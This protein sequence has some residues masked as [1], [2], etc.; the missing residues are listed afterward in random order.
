MMMTT[1]TTPTT[2]T[3]S[4]TKDKD[5]VRLLEV[6]TDH[7]TL[8]RGLRELFS[9]SLF[10]SLERD[11]EKYELVKAILLTREDSIRCTDHQQNLN[12]LATASEFEDWFMKKPPPTSPVMIYTELY[13]RTSNDERKIEELRKGVEE[14]EEEEEEEKE[15]G[16]RKGGASKATCKST[17]RGMERFRS[18]ALHTVCQR[19]A[20]LRMAEGRPS[21]FI[22]S[23]TPDGNIRNT[24]TA[25]GLV[26]ET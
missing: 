4:T 8:S 6:P 26:E 17:K 23:K 19:L 22:P 2:P 15:K 12:I 24:R 11:T 25:F 1:T 13:V 7:K 20:M 5:P 18:A 21:D 9:L 10:L 14:E 16:E 3:T